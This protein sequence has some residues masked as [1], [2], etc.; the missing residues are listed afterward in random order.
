MLLPDSSRRMLPS[1]A[2][3]VGFHKCAE[4]YRSVLEYHGLTLSTRGMPCLKT[5]L[6]HHGELLAGISRMQRS[7]SQSND[8]ENSMTELR[9]LQNSIPLYVQSFVPFYSRGS[10]GLFTPSMVNL[11]AVLALKAK[12]KATMV[13]PSWK[14]QERRRMAR[15]LVNAARKN[16]EAQH[17]KPLD[18]FCKRVKQ[19]IV[20]EQRCRQILV[21]AS[22]AARKRKLDDI[23]DEARKTTSPKLA[24]VS[25]K[26]Q[27]CR[28]SRGHSSQNKTHKRKRVD[29]PNCCRPQRTGGKRRKVPTVQNFNAHVLQELEQWNNYMHDRGLSRGS[30]ARLC[31][32]VL[33][34]LEWLV[35]AEG[36]AQRTVS[37]SDLLGGP[38]REGASAAL[39][40]TSWLE[41]LDGHQRAS[42]SYLSQVFNAFAL[43]AQFLCS[44]RWGASDAH[45]KSSDVGV[46]KALRQAWAS[47]K[48]HVTA[49]RFLRCQ[50]AYS[51]R[52]SDCPQ[53]FQSDLQAFEDYL[54][55][56]SFQRTG[57]VLRKATAR[58]HSRNIL[59]AL[60]WLKKFGSPQGPEFEL[61]LV[62]LVPKSDADGARVA[63]SFL[64]W[65]RKER[66]CSP[67]TEMIALNTFKQLAKYLYQSVQLST[68]RSE[69]GAKPFSNLGV[70]R[71]LWVMEREVAR[72]ASTARPSADID[73]KWLDWPF[74]LK[75]VDC[76]QAECRP[77]TAQ[78]RKR[79]QLAIARSW[80][81]YLLCRMMSVIPDRQRTFRELEL[82]RTLVQVPFSQFGQ[83]FACEAAVMEADGVRCEKLWAIKHSHEDYK[84][85][86]AY[87][88]RPLLPLGPK[89]SRDVDEFISKWRKHLCTGH[90]QFLFCRKTGHPLCKRDIW[91]WL[92]QAMRRVSGKAVNPHLIRDMIVTH[93]R[94]QD[95]SYKQLESLALYMGHSLK[96]QQSTYDKRS[97][98]QKVSPAVDL[99][100][101]IANDSLK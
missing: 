32:L 39:R 4:G 50:S 63:F 46:L 27:N 28:K 20:K 84:T 19:A 42:L 18:E 93:V 1:M 5:A 55:E 56:P 87:G 98:A 61:Q 29:N 85:G 94:S 66:Q 48:P 68:T 8:L 90:H 62:S 9:L 67:K 34:A 35:D 74:F 44:S 79:T 6:A 13:D 78:K 33:R 36:V 37:I 75:A 38:E 72:R 69:P 41:G 10:E 82:G 73:K 43:L 64:A 51:L 49:K 16:A 76:L 23:Q 92:T 96:Q 65:L 31:V 40:Y 52:L 97:Q 24:A 2:K 21:V 17:S 12:L 100:S 53:S 89:V 26:K 59:S 60:G 47:V 91:C 57:P 7:F 83:N 15:E 14:Q 25:I 71:E 77:L 54:T 80:Q 58:V 81:R 86:S 22:N 11:S 3:E 45:G 70:L 30:R 101:S 99:L 95:V 88:E